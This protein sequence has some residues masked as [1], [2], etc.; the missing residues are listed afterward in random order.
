MCC[1]LPYGNVW[2]LPHVK[3]ES[4]L[5]LVVTVVFAITVVCLVLYESSSFV[6]FPTVMYFP[7]R[8]VFQRLCPMFWLWPSQDAKCPVF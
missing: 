7:G 1:S 6:Y 5:A 8:P 3:L 4:V 2:I